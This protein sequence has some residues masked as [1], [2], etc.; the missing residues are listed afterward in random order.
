MQLPD[1]ERLHAAVDGLTKAAVDLAR[2]ELPLDTFGF[3]E[4]EEEPAIGEASPQLGRLHLTDAMLEAKN[5]L[6]SGDSERI[7]STWSTIVKPLTARGFELRAKGLEQE[8]VQTEATLAT[9]KRAEAELKA[10]QQMRREGGSRRGNQQTE[11][12]RRIYAQYR[13]DYQ[14]RVGGGEKPHVALQRVADSMARAG[15]TDPRTNEFPSDD[16]LRKWLRRPD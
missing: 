5:A 6:T 3:F 10:H 1:L 4:G 14:S 2:Y 12:A 7:V 13:I 15:F 11:E 9:A 16:T 8:K